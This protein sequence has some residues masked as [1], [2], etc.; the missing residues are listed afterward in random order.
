MRRFLR[1]LTLVCALVLG[2]CGNDDQS[3]FEESVHRQVS[4]GMPLQA[5]AANLSKLKLECSGTN[6]VDCS[7]IR[8]SLLPY[9]C[10]ERVRLHWSEPD[11]VVDEVEIP[12]IACTGL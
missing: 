12:K 4:L 6:P 7:R 2:G 10:V 3:Q 8:Q 5:A 11:Q 9:S 1:Q